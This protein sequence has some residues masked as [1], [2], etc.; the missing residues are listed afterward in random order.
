MTRRV[1]PE[2]SRRLDALV[3]LEL[4][5]KLWLEHWRDSRSIRTIAAAHGMSATTTWRMIQLFHH[6]SLPSMHGAPNP[7]R[8][9]Q[10]STARCP[11]G[12]PA[13]AGHD[14]PARHRVP[15]SLVP[16]QRCRA[17]PRD[18][19]P[20]GARSLR[21]GLVCTSHGGGTAAAR[22]AARRP[23]QA[24]EAEVPRHLWHQHRQLLQPAADRRRLFAGSD[25]RGFERSEARR[26]RRSA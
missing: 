4:G 24:L 16:A 20:C 21:G 10:R 9:V 5:Q 23:V 12:R 1:G 2:L 6:F 11:R 17:R 13:V 15:R 3:A 14:F 22:A 8:P 25:I 18:S 7:P 26:Q 19:R